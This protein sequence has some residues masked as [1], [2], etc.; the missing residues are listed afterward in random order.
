MEKNLIQA[1]FFGPC[2]TALLLRGIA[3]LVMTRALARW[4][5]GE[6]QGQGCSHTREWSGPWSTCIFVYSHPQIKSLGFRD[7]QW[8]G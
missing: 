6:M 5:R 1:K 2:L 3:L 4:P 8:L 7:W